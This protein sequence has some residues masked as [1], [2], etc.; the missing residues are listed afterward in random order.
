MRG[1]CCIAGSLAVVFLGVL[2]AQAPGQDEKETTPPEPA[3][4]PPELRSERLFKRPPSLFDPRADARGDIARAVERAA[5]ENRRALIVWGADWCSWSRG[6]HMLFTRNERLRREVA[7]EY[8]VV[9]VD[10]GR[11]DRNEELLASHGIDLG[12]TRIPV[13]TILDA[14]GNLLLSE[15]SGFLES[16]IGREQGFDVVKVQEFLV[17]YR[18]TPRDAEASFSA[19]LAAASSSK[20]SLLVHFEVPLRA[21][22]RAFE[23][24]IDSPDVR[25]TLEKDF[26]LLK[27]D[28]QRMTGG[29]ALLA[30]LRDPESEGLPWT[31][32]FDP[33]GRLVGTSDTDGCRNVQFP[34]SDADIAHFGSMLM[35]G[36]LRL[37]RSDIG[38]LEDSLREAR[39]RR[40]ARPKPPGSG[41]DDAEDASPEPPE[42][43]ADSDG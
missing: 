27:I 3:V 34:Q 21:S 40:A 42:S 23:E 16:P 35:K 24:W 10:V 33:N 36:A 32:V 41:D 8:E 39:E 25:A 43:G 26:I 38:S 5:R 19:G 37:F 20:K 15:D 11:Y 31:A 6:L 14:E 2:A 12:R 1:T 9:R 13:V 22:C 29:A 28:T 7:A 4:V 17:R 18:T 30:R